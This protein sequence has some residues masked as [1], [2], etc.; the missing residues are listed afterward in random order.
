MGISLWKSRTA[1]E[2]YQ[3]N[4]YPKVLETLSPMLDGSP[5]VELCDVPFSTLDK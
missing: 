5:R 2:A 1:A 4:T 3:K